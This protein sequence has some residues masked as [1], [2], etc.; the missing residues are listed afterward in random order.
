MKFS[1]KN[2]EDIIFSTPTPLLQQRGLDIEG[3]KL[4][5]VRLGIYGVADLITVNKVYVDTIQEDRSVK[6]IPYLL[7]DIFELKQGKISF[8]TFVQILKYGRGVK[9]YLSKFHPNLDYAI[10]YRMIGDSVDENNSFYF[11]PS[12]FKNIKLYKYIYDYDGINFISQGKHNPIHEGLSKEL[13]FEPNYPNYH[14]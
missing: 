9:S 6:R 14:A 12:L 11:L 10:R 3:A 2:L 5:Q 1:E 13:T 4:R 8:E 7:I